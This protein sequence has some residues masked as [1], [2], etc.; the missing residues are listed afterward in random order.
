L[1]RASALQVPLLA[2]LPEALEALGSGPSSAQLL[3]TR[4]ALGLLCCPAP[5]GAQPRASPA[6][7]AAGPLLLLLLALGATSSLELVPNVAPLSRMQL[8]WR[9]QLL[10]ACDLAAALAAAA[11]QRQQCLL[12]AMGT[13]LLLLGS[14]RM[15]LPCLPR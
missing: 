4:L 15:L 6:A 13:R 12:P 1:L 8:S 3:C 9:L 5:L 7:A 2:A 11:L 14:S 10:L